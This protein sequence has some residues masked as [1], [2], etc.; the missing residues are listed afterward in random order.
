MELKKLIGNKIKTIRKQKGITQEKLAEL[1]GI[2]TPSMSN[3]E[4]GKYSPSIETLQKLAEIL[5]V[6]PYEFY[7]VE[8][9]TLTDKKNEIKNILNENPKLIEITYK[10]LNS[11][12]YNF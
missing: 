9:L 4:T 12:K 10:I 11:I 6:K 7:Q 8:D 2:E 1:I 5:N 3:I